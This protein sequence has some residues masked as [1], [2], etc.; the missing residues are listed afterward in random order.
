VSHRSTLFPHV[1]EVILCILYKLLSCHEFLLFSV[2]RPFN[3]YFSTNLTNAASLNE[4]FYLVCSGE[5]NP[6]AEYRF[7][8]EDQ[9]V[10]S[11]TPGSQNIGLYP[12]S[13]AD[14]VNQVVYK[15]IPFNSFGDGPT[16]TINVT[17][18]CECV[19]MLH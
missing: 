9:I 19:Q 15:C 7:Y 18:H 10:A 14:R 13:V 11:I 8:K 1:K 17:V 3:T 2:Y 6:G 16:R 4:I 12:M 5:A